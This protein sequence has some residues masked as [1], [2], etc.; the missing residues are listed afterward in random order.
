MLI[1]F[2]Y[3]LVNYLHFCAFLGDSQEKKELDTLG[4]FR[5]V[6]GHSN[7]A[8]IRWTNID[9]SDLVVSQQHHC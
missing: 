2:I 5:S 9:V 1:C 3:K 6:A 7:L 4:I 8:I